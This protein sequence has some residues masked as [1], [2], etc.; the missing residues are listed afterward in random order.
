[1]QLELNY[2]KKSESSL[3]ALSPS[4]IKRLLLQVLVRPK[5]SQDYRL[6]FMENCIESS[7]VIDSNI[8]RTGFWQAKVDVI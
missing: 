3:N 4:A 8:L 6:V 2:V 1:M 7:L 5:S